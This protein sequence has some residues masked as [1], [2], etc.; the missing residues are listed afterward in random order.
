[1]CCG[2]CVPVPCVLVG[3]SS[4]ISTCSTVPPLLNRGGTHTRTAPLHNTHNTI[5]HGTTGQHSV[6]ARRRSVREIGLEWG[7]SLAG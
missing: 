2:I 5:T 1:M 3:V 4:Y 6:L 7:P